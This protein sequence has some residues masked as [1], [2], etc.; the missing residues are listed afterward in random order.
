MKTLLYAFMIFIFSSASAQES[1]LNAGVGYGFLSFGSAQGGVRAYTAGWNEE[2]LGKGMTYG[3]NIG[4]R[5]NKTAGI[6]L[7]I[8]YAAG[9]TFESFTNDS[10]QTSAPVSD[11]LIP[12]RIQGNTLRIM[13]SLKL[14]FGNRHQ[15]YLKLGYLLGIANAVDVEEVYPASG[16]SN[17][18]E[19]IVSRKIHGGS[20]NG[21]FAALGIDWEA[22]EKISLFIEANIVIQEYE[23]VIETVEEPGKETITY[24]FVEIPNPNNPLE[25]RI[26]TFPFSTIGIHAGVKFL[27]GIKKKDTPQPAE[28]K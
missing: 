2:T 25:K 9:S 6:D 21:F 1:Y 11:T 17:S 22:R 19:H 7:G 3:F 28:V 26:V 10:Q 18:T 8:W 12:V 24:Q 5:V 16:S 14:S 15:P 4:H 13:P 23:P 20:S 27:L